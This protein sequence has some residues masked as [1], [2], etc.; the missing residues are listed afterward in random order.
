VGIYCPI[1]P[2]ALQA[3]NAVDVTVFWRK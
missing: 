3:D 1:A 2:A